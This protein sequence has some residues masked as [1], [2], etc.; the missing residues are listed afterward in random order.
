M[1]LEPTETA[2]DLVADEYK[3][4]TLKQIEKVIERGLDSFVNVGRAL[5][6]IRERGLY[7]EAGYTTFEAYCR[8]KYDVGRRHAYYLMSGAIVVQELSTNS[9]QNG[10]SEP[11][12]LPRTESVARPLADL[13][14]PEERTEAWQETIELHGDKPTAADV[15]EVVS[16][17]KRGGATVFPAG[18]EP[19]PTVID[20]QTS[21]LAEMPEQLDSALVIT[22]ADDIAHAFKSWP[23]EKPAAVADRLKRSMGGQTNARRR[24]QSLADW[25]AKVAGELSQG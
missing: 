14:T 13:P 7:K 22:V 9:S 1:T 21:P 5:L 23:K 3:D 17:R 16:R 15:R 10:D 25:L 2:T 11:T 19:Q 24:V 4:M 6:A 8:E 12:P 20:V 18:E